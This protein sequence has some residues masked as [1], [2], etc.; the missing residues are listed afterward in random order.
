MYQVIHCQQYRESYYI[1]RKTEYGNTVLDLQN[2]GGD[3]DDEQWRYVSQS[4]GLQ[5][6]KLISQT[7]VIGDI[8]G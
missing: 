2:E 5:S 4:V 3:D 8:Q 7:K 6:S 1:T